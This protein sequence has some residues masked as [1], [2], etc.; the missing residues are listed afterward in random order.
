MCD[1]MWACVFQ[2]YSD[3]DDQLTGVQRISKKI[4]ATAKQARRRRWI[5]RKEREAKSDTIFG[6]ESR[7]DNGGRWSGRWKGDRFHLMPSSV[8]IRKKKKT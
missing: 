8:Y 2:D 5:G 3:D 1:P 7:D 4:D 6:G